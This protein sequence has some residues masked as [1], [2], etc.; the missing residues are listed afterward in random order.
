MS[1]LSDLDPQNNRVRANNSRTFSVSLWWLLA[2][3]LL[4]AGV[5][6]WLYLTTSGSA[7]AS[8]SSPGFAVPLEVS[9]DTYS[10]PTS[11]SAAS[12]AET[13]AFPNENDKGSAIILSNGGSMN[14]AA[15]TLLP[16]A[17]SP[18][19]PEAFVAD[20]PSSTVVLAEASETKTQQ[21]AAP[22]AAKHVPKNPPVKAGNAKKNNMATNQPPQNANDKARERDVDIIS[23]IVR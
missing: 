8:S 23:I 7:D 18:A 17:V 21:P 10:A 12:P 2:L 15:D 1:I 22:P 9:V 5:V 16:Q 3:P 4:L 14:N 11:D 20:H 13:P 19:T 6:W